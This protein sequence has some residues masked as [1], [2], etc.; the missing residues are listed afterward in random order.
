MPKTKSLTARM[1]LDAIEI[2]DEHRARM[3]KE[4]TDGKSVSRSRALN[5]LV[6]RS[7]EVRT[8]PTFIPERPEAD[9]KP[10]RTEKPKK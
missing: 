6:Y 4:R 9:K 10:A 8:E 3:Q 7:A 2:V 1:E 5:D